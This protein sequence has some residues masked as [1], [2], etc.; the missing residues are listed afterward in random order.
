M[1]SEDFL[2]ATSLLFSSQ[3]I[4]ALE[5]SFDTA[6]LRDGE[7]IPDWASELIDYWSQAGSLLGH[8]V[9]YSAFSGSWT[10]Y[11]DDWLDCFAYE[12]SQRN[13]R[14]IS[15]HWG[16]SQAL[17]FVRNSP[18]PA[19]LSPVALDLASA[20]L[21][22]LA[23][24]SGAPVGLEN[25]AFAFSRDDLVNQCQFLSDLLLE[26]DGFLVLDL[27]NS[28]CQ[29]ENFKLSASELLRLYPLHRVKELHLSGGSW[30]SYEKTQNSQTVGQSNEQSNRQAEPVLIRRDTH[31][32]SVPEEVFQL[33][34]LALES[35]PNLEFVILE[36]LANTIANDA[37]GEK[38]RQ[39]FKKMKSIV[40]AFL[41]GARTRSA[42]MPVLAAPQR[43]S[44]GYDYDP[45]KIRSEPGLAEFQS[46]LLLLLDSGKDASEIRT[47]LLQDPEIARYHAY[48]ES[49]EEPML[50]LAKVLTRKWGVRE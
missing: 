10:S 48:V 40:Q 3:E 35:C 27:H 12:C 26:T 42:S 39:D 29:M 19:L 9:N 49:W 28:Y 45:G 14:H 11:Q 22:M 20:R 18:M 25:L 5:W 46:K 8:G 4:E 13:F 6:W 1:P 47:F 31:D 41:S 15:E 43:S 34:E 2:S 37:E 33:L 38:L 36:R 32:D 16:F 24:I 17:P 21:S 30:S 50:D 23:E 44:G 7:A